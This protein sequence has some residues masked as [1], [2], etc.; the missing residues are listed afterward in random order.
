VPDE[1]DVYLDGNKLDVDRNTKLATAT[2]HATAP[3]T[4]D[5]GYFIALTPEGKPRED[6]SLGRPSML[7]AYKRTDSILQGNWVNLPWQG[8]KDNAKYAATGADSFTMNIGAFAIFIGKLPQAKSIRLEG[9]YIVNTTTG[10]AG[11]G[12][13]L[14]NGKQVMRVPAGDYPYKSHTFSQDISSYAGQYVLIE[15]I[16][17]GSVRG[18]SANWNQP[19]IVVDE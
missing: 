4:G 5:L 10:A 14:I 15:V 12:V 16:A 6:V 17:D 11:D 13:V 19:S 7:L 18:A 3:K 8:S 1:Y 2:I 9:S